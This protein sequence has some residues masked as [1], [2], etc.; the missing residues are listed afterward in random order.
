VLKGELG[1]NGFLISDWAAIDQLP[2]D[3]T[4]DIETSINAGLDMIMVPDR[5]EEFINTTKS[6][7][8]DNRISME[9]INDA[10]S[11]ILNVKFELGLFENPLTDRTFTSTIGSNQHRQIARDAVRQSL[12]L[13]KNE[14]NRL[15][16]RKDSLN[17]HVAGKNADDLGNQCGGWTIS[18][19]GGSGDI[20]WGTNILQAIRTLV[21]SSTNVTYS[22]DGSGAAGSDV[23]IAVIGERPYA[24]GSGDRSDLNLDTE[25]M[26]TIQNFVNAGIPVITILISG[27]PMI[28][29]QALE[30]SDAFIAAWLPGTEGL[31]VADILFGDFA[32]T[33]KLSHSWPRSMSQIPINVG[34]S[35]YDPLFPYGYGLTY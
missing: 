31:G 16:L 7:V 15:P 12:V 34:D 3:Y 23:G 1:F 8:Q 25:D 27:R 9:R 17:I 21:N 6:L 19:Q 30:D 14:N 22:Y 2:G 33:G 5:Y 18:W 28:I 13:L 29:N 35:N 26:N 11:R 24:E 32:P 20:T 10:V 4:S